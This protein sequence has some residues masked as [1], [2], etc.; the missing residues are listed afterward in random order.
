MYT[1]E[2]RRRRGKRI[3][4]CDERVVPTPYLEVVD[5]SVVKEV[6]IDESSWFPTKELNLFRE[7]QPGFELKTT[8]L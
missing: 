6:A 1:V 5:L 4:G 3:R 2:R 7:M 8:V